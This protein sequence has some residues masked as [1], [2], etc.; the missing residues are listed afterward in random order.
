[1]HG[2]A[3][4]LFNS[5]NLP[6]NHPRYQC[7]PSR[8]KLECDL[9]CM[10]CAACCELKTPETAMH[11]HAMQ[12][13]ATFKP[14]LIALVSDAWCCCN[15]LG[16]DL[17]ALNQKIAQYIYRAHGHQL[18]PRE[19]PLRSVF[20]ESRYVARCTRRTGERTSRAFL[21][22]RRITVLYSK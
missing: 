18:Q 12:H 14:S 19:Q 10:R 16:S 11:I 8:F 15:L 22:T 1:M 4:A 9:R 7:N 21:S 2:N 6:L 17:E 13:L 20:E 3:R 5:L